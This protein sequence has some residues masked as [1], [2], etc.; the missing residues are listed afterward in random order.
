MEIFFLSTSIEFYISTGRL[1]LLRCGKDK[2]YIMVMARGTSRQAN[3]TLAEYFVCTN[4]FIYMT[5]RNNAIF[6]AI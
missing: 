4:N 3:H 6:S 2:G 5:T 1:N